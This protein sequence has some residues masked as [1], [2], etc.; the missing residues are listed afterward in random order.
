[1]GHRR[2]GGGLHQRRRM[3]AGAGNARGP[4]PPGLVDPGMG[5]LRF[6]CRAF[7]PMADEVSRRRVRLPAPSRGP[8]PSAGFACWA[9]RPPPAFAGPAVRRHGRTDRRPEQAQRQL[10]R[11]PAAAAHWRRWLQ[12]TRR[13]WGRMP[14]RRSERPGCVRAITVDHGEPGIEGR[15]APGVGAPVDGDG[16]NGARRWIEALEGAAPGGIAGDAAGRCDRHQPSARREHG[17]GRTEVTQIRV[18][19]GALNPGACRE[20]RVHQHDGGM[21]V[22][23]DSRR[24]PRRCGG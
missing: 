12:A 1:M 18:V 23:A 3:F 14:A 9:R 21:Q 6:V 17:E 2:H 22:R 8:A 5:C 13:P 20:R 19:T 11:P 16:K 24:W 10:A 4:G 7:S 15:A